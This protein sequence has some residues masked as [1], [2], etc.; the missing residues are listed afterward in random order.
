MDLWKESN[1]LFEFKL[2]RF[3]R[4]RIELSAIKS[5]ILGS[6]PAEQHLRL[7]GKQ[8]ICSILTTLHDTFKPDILTRYHELNKDYEALCMPPKNKPIDKWFADWNIFLTHADTCPDYHVNNMQAM[9][10]F[11]DAIE[12]I[13]PMQVVVKKSTAKSLSSTEINLPAISL[14]LS[15]NT[16]LSKP[17]LLSPKEAY[18]APFKDNLKVMGNRIQMGSQTITK[19]KRMTASAAASI[20]LTTAHMSIL[21]AGKPDGHQMQAFRPD[22]TNRKHLLCK[23]LLITPADARISLS[24]LSKTFCSKGLKK[25]LQFNALSQSPNLTMFC[26]IASLQTQ[27]PTCISENILAALSI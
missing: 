1:H 13:L 15:K 8:S 20:D 6:I 22:L 27:A 7:H 25:P 11:I 5:T 12:P 2:R 26:A 17:N 21:Q 10:Q 23:L 9:M 18:L 24:L 14:T 16:P 19:S 4:N 3:E